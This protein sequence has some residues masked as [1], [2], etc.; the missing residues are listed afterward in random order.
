MLS[1]FGP[2]AVL[3]SGYPLFSA[4]IR[5][6]STYIGT[7]PSWRLFVLGIMVKMRL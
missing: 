2:S 7:F 1:V 5:Y 6:S 3:R 4:K